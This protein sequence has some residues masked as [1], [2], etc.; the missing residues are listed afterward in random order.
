MPG[1]RRREAACSIAR[2]SIFDRGSRRRRSLTGGEPRAWCVGAQVLLDTPGVVDGRNLRGRRHRARV[3]SA[4]AAAARCDV[5]VFLVDAQRQLAAPDPRLARLLAGLAADR[6][7]WGP[8]P[9]AILALNKMDL[10]DPGAPEAFH[11]MRRELAGLHAFAVRGPSPHP[12]RRPRSGG[13]DEAAASLPLPPHSP[14]RRCRRRCRSRRRRGGARRRCWRRSWRT[15][16]SGP[17][18]WTGPPPPTRR[19]RWRG[20]LCGRSSS[21]G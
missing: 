20:R 2:R 7:D 11:A 8:V 4:W 1:P 14:S 16:R 12:A 13:A 10:V 3:A 18:S 5:L 6:G 15:A 19:S 9:P 21:S 17:G